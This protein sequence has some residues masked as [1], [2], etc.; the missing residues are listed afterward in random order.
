MGSCRDSCCS[1]RVARMSSRSPR[2]G[3]GQVSALEVGADIGSDSEFVQDVAAKNTAEIELSRMALERAIRPDVRSF[4]Q[5]IIDEHRAAGN[6]LKTVLSGQGIDWPAQLDDE[7]EE[8][9]Q[10]DRR[11]RVPISIASTSGQ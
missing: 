9:D 7:H 11:G 1:T 10:R 4:A 5:T 8:D 6:Q 3:N 2:A